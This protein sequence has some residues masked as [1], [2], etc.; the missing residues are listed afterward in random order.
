M[1]S[2]QNRPFAR[3]TWRGNDIL[4]DQKEGAKSGVLEWA[5]E[6]E[7]RAK[8]LAH[9]VTGAMQRATGMVHP[10]DKRIFQGPGAPTVSGTIKDIRELHGSYITTITSLVSYAI[11]EEVGRGH[12]FIAPAVQSVNRDV[13]KIMVRN[14]QKHVG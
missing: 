11:V 12:Q 4:K 9:V 6:A 8:Q 10:L 5:K 2:I 7:R 13:G 1:A 14:V 3:I